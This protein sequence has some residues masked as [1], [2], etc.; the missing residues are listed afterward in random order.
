[1]SV[2][3]EF[4]YFN[5]TRIVFGD[6]KENEV[7]AILQGYGFRSVLVL[8][9]GGSAVR[10]GLLSRVEASLQKAGIAYSLMG[11]VRP[12][13]EVSFVR[14]AVKELRKN[15]KD[16]ILA[17]GGGSVIDTAKSI[18]ISYYYDGD[19]FDFNLYKA[20]AKKTL[21]VGVILT[22]ASAGSESSNSCV[23]QDDGLQIKQGFN[24]DVIRPLFA[25]ES[26]SLMSGVPWYQMAAGISDTILHSLER[27]FAPSE[28]NDIAD[29]FALS[30]IKRVM[31]VGE[32]LRK[33]PKDEAAK[34]Q[35]MLL[36][37][38]SHDGLTN[39]GK[40]QSFV[41]HPLEH[42]LSAYRPGIVHGA[43]V[44][45]LFPAWA[46]HVFALDLPKFA[47]MGKEL[48]S[49]SG[50]SEEE[51]AIMG[52]RRMK[53]FFVS[54]GMPS[55]LS[56]V[57]IASEDIPALVDLATGNGTRVVGRFPKPLTKQDIEDIYSSLLPKEEL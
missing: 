50:T 40:Q 46:N 27:Y 14:D 29:D 16:A 19:P 12:N 39:I 48:F 43:G 21:P 57:G 22:I 30:V 41:V 54:L 20:E 18:G 52:I 7:G 17:V 55:S 53:E 47:R 3:K 42:V 23:L 56:E 5:P 9:G 15:P 32:I 34:G 8:Y 1:M 45:M 6:G 24:N 28:D 44:A 2:K 51:V 10:S 13:P 11:G 25:I 49:L 4:E 38:L 33:N 35:L 36:S 31:K 26:P 37:S